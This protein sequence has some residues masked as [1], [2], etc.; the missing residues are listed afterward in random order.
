MT[1]DITT[2]PENGIEIFVPLNKLKKS[3]KNA[4]RTPHASAAIDALAA[5][6]A[7]KGMLQNLVVEADRGEDG[8]ETGYYL[9]TIGE[10]RRLAHLLRA[11]RKEIRKSE[12]I[13]CVLDVVNDP[14]EIS[15]D[16]NV[17]RENMHP[18]DQ[19]EA[20]KRLA[21]ERGLGA[22]EIGARFGVTPQVVRQ[23]M[24]LGAISPALMA[25]YR[26]GQITLDQLMAFTL[27]DDHDKQERVWGELGW[28]KSRDAIRHA[29]TQDQAR[30]T[31]RR[32]RFVGIESYEAAGG[33]ITRDLFDEQNNGYL[34]DAS[35]LDRLVREKL[36]GEAQ[37]VRTEGWK[38]VE[39]TA[40]FD[41]QMVAGM[42]RVYPQPA[43]PT[44]E[45]ASRIETLEAEFE[46]L[47]IRYD[48]EVP[49]DIAPEFERLETEIERL[50]GRQVYDPDVI[51][52]G[53]AFVALGHDG[54]LRIERGFIRKEDEAVIE[55][56]PNPAEETAADGSENGEGADEDVDMPSP[57]SDKLVAELSAHRTAALRDRLAQHPEVA[58]L[59]LVHAMAAKTFYR[60]HDLGSC[61][62][63]DPR[64]PALSTHAPGIDETAARRATSERHEDWAKRLPEQPDDLWAFVR[65][66][67]RQDQM[68]LLAHC[69]ALTVDVLAVK[70]ERRPRREINSAT[71]AQCLGLDM[72]TYWQ[73]TP[74]NYLAR[75]S[76]SRIVEAVTEAVGE[77][78]A[79]QIAGHKKPAMVEAA[80]QL[81]GGKNWLP[82][83]LRA[84]TSPRVE[85]ESEPA[86]IAT[87]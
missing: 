11:K 82:A 87:E 48:G 58:F 26:E 73:P 13:R 29:L 33:L 9:V 56:D 1:T 10:G 47:S 8:A 80:T 20:F 41:Y 60:G 74:A 64:S 4:R 6:I 77:V 72:A 17:T 45:D 59:A 22:E 36:E 84:P 67:D 21:E 25:I 5:S 76:K 42:R 24:K 7:A 16:E 49:D 35:L 46:N 38:W 79:D 50:R 43:Q 70:W 61:L 30:A 31:D 40:E 37:P 44:E 3:P 75:V 52:R 32:A 15:L 27:T 71:L 51:A 85:V 57:L 66:L 2:V 68:A 53:G 63:I 12:P 81:L 19:Y 39:V 55:A 23:R 54:G 83:Q 28:N 78:A 14:H 65:D 86:G 62:E 18:A 34:P 69:V